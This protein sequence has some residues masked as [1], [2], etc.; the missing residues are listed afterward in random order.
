MSI[1]AE[2]ITMRYGDTG[3]PLTI[4]EDLSFQIEDQKHVAIVGASGIG[5]TT[6]LHLIGGLDRPTSGQVK[7]CGEVFNSSTR[8]SDKV[9]DFRS[10]NIGFIFQ[11]H[12]LLPEFSAVENVAMPLML[13]DRP[14]KKYLDIA[15]E[16]L[17]KL[18]LGQRLDHKP[19]MLSGGEQQRVAIA[20]AFSIKPKVVLADEPTGNL[21]R[22]TA[23][24]VF[25]VLRA[26]TR[27]NKA[28]LLMVTHSE[29]LALKMDST[30]ELRS[31][32]LIKKEFK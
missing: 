25:N 31:N 16:L 14:D 26:L 17:T 11:F 1:E 13:R 4:F 9:T 28:T 10:K 27:E 20:R 12:N 22:N 23:E 32:C 2:N 8:E 6:L 29:A 5:K 30:L 15:S 19:P 18:G 3:K 24:D 7:I 21:D